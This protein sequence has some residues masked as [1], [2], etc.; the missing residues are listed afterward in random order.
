M[1][2]R[3]KIEI[4]EAQLQELELKRQLAV[5][6]YGITRDVYSSLVEYLVRE[7]IVSEAGIKKWEAEVL[8]IDM[9]AKGHKMLSQ[10]EAQRPLIIPANGRV[11]PTLKV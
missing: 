1:S 9:A 11:I 3:A 7:K 10:S 5:K 2:N 6:Q 8:P 4:L